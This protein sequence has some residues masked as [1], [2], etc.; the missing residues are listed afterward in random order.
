MY[1]LTW[2]EKR[3]DMYILT[4]SDKRPF[5]DLSMRGRCWEICIVNSILA[6]LRG[7]HQGLH[8][9]RG[10]LCEGQPGPPTPNVK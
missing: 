6:A 5:P 2:R 9:V 10:L 1:I 7:T 3:G 4:W 8:Y